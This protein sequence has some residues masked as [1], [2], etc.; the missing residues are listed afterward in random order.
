[1]NDVLLEKI[2]LDLS[3]KKEDSELDENWRRR[4][5]YSVT[6]L[7][8]LASLYDYEDANITDD[9]NTDGKEQEK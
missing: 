4:V 9:E 3:I 1:M 5:L 7:Q 6:G 2:A 8:M